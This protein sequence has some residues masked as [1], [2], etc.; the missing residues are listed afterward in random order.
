MVLNKFN[1]WWLLGGECVELASCKL[2][3][4]EVVAESLQ[5]ILCP[6]LVSYIPNKNSSL[7]RT[8]FVFLEFLKWRI[9]YCLTP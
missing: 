9:C 7:I 8:D 5:E 6:V 4:E 2:Q 1:R 3:E